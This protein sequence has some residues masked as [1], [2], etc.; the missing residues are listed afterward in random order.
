MS[1]TS[2]SLLISLQ[3]RLLRAQNMAELSFIVANDTWQLIKYQ[4]GCVYFNNTLGQL[5]LKNVTGLVSI[6]EASPFTVWLDQLCAV[7]HAKHVG[8][9]PIVVAREAL[10]EALAQSWG[11]WWPD[12][13]LFV[14][15][16]GRDGS[17][18]GA[19]LLVRKEPWQ[20]AELQLLG[21]LAQTWG[22]CAEALQKR[23]F[24]KGVRERLRLRPWRVGLVVLILLILAIPVRLS[25]LAQAEI[26]ALKS[27]TVTAPM[28]GVIKRFLVPPNSKVK[29]GDPLFTLDEAPL[30]NQQRIAQQSLEVVRSEAHV[31][32]QRAFDQLESKAE[33]AALLGKVREKE[34]E[35]AYLQ[36]SLARTTIH[37]PLDGIFVY[38]DANDWIGKPVV[39]GERVGELAQADDL[40]VLMWLPVADAIN[41]EPGA[42]IRV[43][44]QV[45]PL[46]ALEATLVQTSYQASLSP[47]G[48]ASYHLR[49][50]LKEGGETRFGLRGV[51]KVYGARK[52][53]GYWMMRRPMGALRQWLGV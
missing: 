40:G 30:R 45:A 34:L 8:P 23:T 3:Q 11:E 18:Q 37:A 9:D 41:L 10:D 50:Q 16:H 27:E 39:T 22:Y 29:K 31:A 51:A 15:C 53:L 14:P 49:G 21:I 52:A 47:E 43:F 28:E 12:H 19:A 25:A 46:D 24:L 26:I 6:Q 4:Q 13:A 7:M 42:D 33:L 20:E 35:L 32:Q 2:V 36:E 17:R 44:L 5:K 38:S 48:V 1:D